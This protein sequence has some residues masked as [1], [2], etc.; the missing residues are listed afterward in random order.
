LRST[1]AEISSGAYILPLTLKRT[2]PSGPAATSNETAVNS[3]STSSN[4]L[5][6]NRF[7]D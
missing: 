2:A 6:M 1:R 5:P 4:R 7:A 3:L